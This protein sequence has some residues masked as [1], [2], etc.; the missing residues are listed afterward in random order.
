MGAGSGAGDGAG[1]GSGA[2]VGVGSGVGVGAGLGAGL[3]AG[4]P[5]APGSV[6]VEPPPP[7]HAARR[8]ETTASVA[9]VVCNLEPKREQVAMK[10]SLHGGAIK[11]GGSR[12]TP[13]AHH[14]RRGS[15]SPWTQ[16]Y[17]AGAGP[18]A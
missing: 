9:T 3:G 4:V 16:R 10:A 12:R 13:G 2:G 1:V 11:R 14:G 17:P 8:A 5:L 18:L 7:P 15:A 6:D